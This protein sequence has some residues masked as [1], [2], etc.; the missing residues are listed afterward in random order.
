MDTVLDKQAELGIAW[1]GDG[2]AASSSTKAVSSARRLPDRS[3]CGS[4][5]REGPGAAIIYDV[6]RAVPFPDT[7]TP[8]G[9]GLS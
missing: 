1:D 3:A 2:D 9:A 4:G 7:I 8:Q 6:R 5:A